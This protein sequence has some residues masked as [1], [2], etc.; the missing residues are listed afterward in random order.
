MC[1]SD[2]IHGGLT[3]CMLLP[4]FLV[5]CEVHAFTAC[6]EVQVPWLT[7][8]HRV[9]CHDASQQCMQCHHPLHTSSDLLPP[10]FC[11]VHVL[12]CCWAMMP[13]HTVLWPSTLIGYCT[14]ASARH[15]YRCDQFQDMFG[16]VRTSLTIVS[17][18]QWPFF[19]GPPWCQWE[20]SLWGLQVRLLCCKLIDLIYCH[21]PTCCWCLAVKLLSLDTGC[22]NLWADHCMD[23]HDKWRHYTAIVR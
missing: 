3:S 17:T 14:S 19:M 13:V 23:Q 4:S 10:C 7:L 6:C 9:S 8:L 21:F 11:C 18:L 16:I 12:S 15:C 2:C 1:A 22:G 20:L 5:P